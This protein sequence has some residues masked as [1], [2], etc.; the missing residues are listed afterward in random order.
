MFP[1]FPIYTDREAC[2]ALFEAYSNMDSVQM[3]RR[4]ARVAGYENCV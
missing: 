2:L 3:K 4:E 1:A